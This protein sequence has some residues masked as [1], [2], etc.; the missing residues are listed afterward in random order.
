M[1]HPCVL[2]VLLTAALGAA[3]AATFTSTRDGLSVTAPPGWLKR[4]VA[5]VTVKYAAPTTIQGFRPNI[6]VVVQTLKTPM[7]LAQYYA[8]SAA[9]L[10]L[11][12]PGGKILGNAPLTFGGIKGSQTTY[13]GRQGARTLYYQSAYILRGKK[14]YLITG[15]TLKGAGAEA[16]LKKVMTP[17]VKSFRFTK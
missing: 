16:A 5:G 13:Q 11:L 6:N 10:K 12:L 8:R 15:T 7:T 14:A 17:F 2:P 3:Q 4:D 9:D 1:R